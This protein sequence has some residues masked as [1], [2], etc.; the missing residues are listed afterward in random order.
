MFKNYFILNRL[1]L[2]FNQLLKEAT[3]VSCFSQDKN[4][5]LFE[6]SKNEKTHFVEIS[7]SPG[8]QYMVMKDSYHRANKNSIDIF[9]SIIGEI[10][11][12]LQIAGNDRIIRIQLENSAVY[13]TIRGKFSN[14]HLVRGNKIFSFKTV[15][16]QIEKDFLEESKSHN[17]ISEFNTV[18]DLNTPADISLQKLKENHPIISKEII[19]EAQLRINDEQSNIVST[20]STII[21]EIG[22]LTPVLYIEENSHEIFI[23]VN[24]FRIFPFTSIIKYDT[25][26]EALKYYINKRYYYA[27][28]ELKYKLINKHLQR[29]LGKCTSRLNKIDSLLTRESKEEFYN[30]IANL[31]LINIHKLKKGMEVIEVEDIYTNGKLITVKINDTISP[32][33][34]VDNYFHKAKSERVSFEKNKL[35][36]IK[37]DNIYKHLK[38]K[39]EQLNGTKSL[40]VL[41]DFIKE[42]GIK[43]AEHKSANDD[44]SQKFKHYI[45]ENKYHVFVGKDSKNN[46]LLTTRF[47]KHNDYW[48]HARSVPGSHVVLRIDN[49]K[50]A[51]PKNILKSAASIAAH[52]SKAKTAGVVPV[53]Y[54]LKKYVVKKKG[55][56]PG[57]VALLKEEV[58]LV[59]PELP[60]NCEYVSSE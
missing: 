16:E 2:E 18:P 56:E 24:S 55:M 58:L 38:S 57:K 4:K 48:F 13:F 9:E 39:E 14:I 46:D 30:K 7:V 32:K 45:L 28:W 10:L 59:T 37:T 33:Q 11:I 27:E 35:L 19:R 17:F 25:T 26:N 60:K 54:A 20:V 12:E 50:E 3:L 34:N 8:F 42:L 51:V 21:S 52:H 40:N 23:S 41:N 29:E 53:S 43:V 15:E 1:I 5:L 47:A 36:K 44:I 31:L 6:L 49:S 22:S